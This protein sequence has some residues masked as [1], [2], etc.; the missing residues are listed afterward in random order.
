MKRFSLFL[1]L[2]L[3]LAAQHDSIFLAEHLAPGNPS[4][5][6]HSISAPGNYLMVR[7]QYVLSYNRFTGTPNWTA[8]HLDSAWLGAIRRKN[9]FRSDSS[10]PAQ[11]YRVNELSYRHSGYDRGHMCPSG[12]RTNT[13]ENNAMTFLMTN[14]V[15]QAPNNNQGP[16]AALELYCRKLVKEGNELYIYSGGYGS[17]GFLDS[18]RV[19][20]PERTWKVI[21]VLPAGD[22]DRERMTDSTR[23]IAVDMPNDNLL[24]SKHDDWK[25][26]R[27]T[28]RSVEKKTGFD[29]LSALPTT[30]QSVLE[31]TIDRR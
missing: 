23:V 14:M 27:T 13:A 3:Q 30:I 18:G 16:W 1:F 8:W 20:V 10:L 29:F 4:N 12:D 21:V 2:T 24:I 15:P 7:K 5:A 9:N 25:A 11:W 19:N 17:N 31:L 6:V 22:R 28:I 26:F